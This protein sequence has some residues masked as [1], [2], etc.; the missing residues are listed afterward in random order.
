MKKGTKVYT[1]AKAQLVGKASHSQITFPGSGS[2][3]IFKF[4]DA[5]LLGW[6]AIRADA[7]AK[8]L[9]ITNTVLEKIKKS[10]QETEKK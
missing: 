2:G 8:N 4:S 5:E 6:A 9:G 1:V 7:A 10:L 3:V